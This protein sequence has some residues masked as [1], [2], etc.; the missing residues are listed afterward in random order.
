MMRKQVDSEL[1]SQ[2]SISKPPI[3]F[4]KISKINVDKSNGKYLSDD[5]ESYNI[6]NKTLMQLDSNEI[7]GIFWEEFDF[8]FFYET[9][10]TQRILIYGISGSGKSFFAAQILI[11]KIIHNMLNKKKTSFTAISLTQSAKLLTENLVY[12]MLKRFPELHATFNTDKCPLKFSHSRNIDTLID[13][14]NE[15]VPMSNDPVMMKLIAAEE[16]IWILDDVGTILSKKTNKIKDFFDTLASNGRHFNITFIISSQKMGLPETLLSQ[17]DKTCFVGAICENAWQ[18]FRKRIGFHLSKKDDFYYHYIQKIGSQNSNN[19]LIY[20]K[21]DF[22]IYF[23]KVSN[24]FV[25][26]WEGRMGIDE[27]EKKR[28]LKRLQKKIE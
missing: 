19:I 27:K 8:E 24:V 26:Y 14:L 12:F 10:T 28:R 22:K 4:G 3:P 6:N 7:F 9:M 18:T 15:F 2:K 5:L 25:K 17:I 1:Q 23:H 21:A 16:K 20:D 13:A 11:H